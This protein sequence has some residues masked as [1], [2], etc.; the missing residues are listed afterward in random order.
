MITHAIVTKVFKSDK[1]KDGSPYVTKKGKPFF[2]IGIKTDKTGEDWYSCLAFETTSKEYNLKEGDE[3]QFL[4]ELKDGN[5]NFKI[6]TIADLM[7]QEL[8]EIRN[9]LSRLEQVTGTP[10]GMPNFDPKPKVED[11]T[12]DDIPFD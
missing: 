2:K 5:K 11:I 9:R 8:V 1:K 3:C 6:P 10:N 7:Q 4:F 12:V